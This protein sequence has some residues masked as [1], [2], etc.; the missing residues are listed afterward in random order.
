MFPEIT[1]DYLRLKLSSPVVVGSCPLALKPDAVQELAIA[2]AGAVVLP[3]LF[4]EQVVR[5]LDDQGV[6]LEPQEAAVGAAGTHEIEEEHNGGVAR[7][8]AAIEQLKRVTAIPVIANLYG[9]TDGNWLGLARQLE[10]CGADALELSLHTDS[11]DTALSP[12]AIEQELLNCVGR[13]CSLV[14]MPVAV[15][16]SPFLSSLANFGGRLA[17]AG[18]SGIVVFGREPE[19]DIHTDRLQATARWPL[20]A[21]GN[22][23]TM[24]AG[25]IR[26]RSGGLTVSIAASGGIGSPGD[27]VKAALVGADVAMVTSEV[28]REG[29]DAVRHMVEGVASFLSR[30]NYP[31]LSALLH[32]R[33]KPDRCR[34]Q[35]QQD[36]VMRSSSLG[37]SSLSS[38]ARSSGREQ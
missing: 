10:R 25:V 32:A 3:S 18:A 16:L 14:S 19:W 26:A 29:P 20:T 22:T 21:A 36:A 30:H 15:K 12:A 34:W 6:E 31:S 13:V 5:Y 9:Y 7:Y 2:G 11:T 33:P 35:R 27:V 17:A 4:E 8:L 23:D 24:I 1:A 28:Y 38:G 37:S